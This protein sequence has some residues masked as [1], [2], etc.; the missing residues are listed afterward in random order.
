VL[1]IDIGKVG[2]VNEA[3]STGFHQLTLKS[4]VM[5]DW[6][7]AYPQ[8]MRLRTGRLLSIVEDDHPV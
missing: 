5:M 3:A 4:K 7:E 1:E 8:S 2:N 6:W